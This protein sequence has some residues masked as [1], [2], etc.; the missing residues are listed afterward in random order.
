M[1]IELPKIIHIY[2]TYEYGI[3]LD[4]SSK[5]HVWDQI[6][7]SRRLYNDLVSKIREI[8]SDMQN[9]VIEQAGEQ[10]SIIMA[11]ITRLN[12]SFK[13]AKSD[14]DELMMKT[15][16]ESRREQWRVLSPILKKIRSEHKKVLQSQFF[17]KIGNNSSTETYPI[18]CDYVMRG[19]GWATATEVLNRALKAW[20][21]SMK[22]GNAPKFA[23]SSG[24]FQDT[25]VLQFTA[26]G[27]LPVNSI[28][29]GQ[30]KEIGVE[31]T[32]RR[33]EFYFRLGA[34]SSN[35]YATG[36]IT[37]HRP[38]PLGS[39]P[40]ARLVCKKFAD[41]EKYFL[42]FVV[43]HD[44]EITVNDSREP[45]LAVHF[46]W[47]SDVEGRRV[48]AINAT[49]D[50]STAKLIQL[51]V[52]IEADLERASV[53]QGL[54]D[55]TLLSLHPQLKQW[56]ATGDE[57]LDAEITIIQRLPHTHLAQSRIHRLIERSW[58]LGYENQPAWLREW[59]SQDKKL[60]QS[61][62]G[63]ARRARDRRNRFYTDLANKW[64]KTYAAIVIE[65]LDLKTSATKIDERSGKKSEFTRAARAGQRVAALYELESAIRWQAV[66]HGTAVFEETPETVTICAHCHTPGLKPLES[67]WQTLVCTH[68]GAVVD[69]KENGATV[70]YQLTYPGIYQ[71]TQHYHTESM[72]KENDRLIKKAEKLQK[73]QQVRRDLIKARTTSDV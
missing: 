50:P 73:I 55:E 4:E 23:R 28:L 43:S 70:L 48:S 18:R 35:Q 8:H 16:A 14:N 54:R 58:A 33:G 15:V 19:L 39:I 13:A 72:Q 1:S 30:S 60:W 63:I 2:N 25:L 62:A 31:V 9:Y 69:R 45:L 66:K 3:K 57:N 7:L 12:D 40:G 56:P 5:K 68:C 71:R 36:E 27:G 38:L 51:P 6:I 21:D 20:K 47:S 24:K 17:S 61:Q 11:E 32:A 42:Q 53:V 67:D 37:Y 65:P 29:T 59:K 22:L 41:G 44:M 26:A 52:D 46:G 49:H 34:A 10:A 64:C